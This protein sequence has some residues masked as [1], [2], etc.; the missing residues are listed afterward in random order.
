MENIILIKN[1]TFAYNKQNPV[2][3]DIN[4]QIYKGD[5]ITLLG[6]NGVGKSTLL[7]CITGLLTV[8]EGTIRLNNFDI[9]KL[10]IK[11]IAQNIAYVQQKFQNNFDYTVR[12]YVTMG[13][14]AH[15]NIFELPTEKDYRIA[16]EAL[17]KMSNSHL[18]KKT[19]REIS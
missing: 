10:K 17:E 12:E 16:D 7:N 1:L 3:N 15:K 9:S 13:R 8:M 4:A 19:Y 11:N 14:T 6:P 5:L 2:L 18:Q